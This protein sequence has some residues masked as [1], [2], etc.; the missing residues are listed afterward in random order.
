MI[1]LD[2]GPTNKELGED[3]RKYM[4]IM[5]KVVNR[6]ETVVEIEV[7]DVLAVSTVPQ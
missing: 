2:V 7:D 6:E 5:Q 4:D 3:A 1:F